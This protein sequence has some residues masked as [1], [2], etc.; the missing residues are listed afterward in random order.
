MALTWLHL[1]DL[2]VGRKD[3]GQRLALQSLIKAVEA[4]TLGRKCDLVIF[5]G[6]VANSGS[7]VEYDEFV[8]SILQP[9]RKMPATADAKY[10]ATP[11]NHDLDC[12]LTIPSPWSNLGKVR[13]SLFF[14]NSDKGRQVREPRARGFNEYA[15][16]CERNGIV[17]FDPIRGCAQLI[18][19]DNGIEALK[20]IAINTALFSDM[21]ESDKGL[22][23]APTLALRN[24]LEGLGVD[25][26][27]LIIGHHP[28]D[29]F[30]HTTQEQFKAA[31][32]EQCAVYLHGHE[33]RVRVETNQ[34]G[35]LSLGF[36]AAYQAP[37]DETDIS[38]Y[39]NGFAVCLLEERLHI[40]IHSWDNQ[41]GVWRQQHKLPHEFDCPSEM[42][43][44]G[45]SFEFPHRRKRTA[46]RLV[47][48]PDRQRR[49]PTC[50]RVVGVDPKPDRHAWV[51]LLKQIGV[52]PTAVATD[53]VTLAGAT[54]GVLDF[55][56]SDN[57]ATIFIR[58][59][60]GP[61]HVLSAREV[62]AANT[63]MDTEAH[64][65]LIIVSF[66]ELADDARK[67][68][69]QLERR[70]S[71]RILTNG[72][73]ARILNESTPQPVQ[74][75]LDELDAADVV[76][77]HVLVAPKRFYAV[78]DRL[79][80]D[81][82]YLLDAQ[83]NRLAESDEVVVRLRDVYAELR[84][85]VY[86]QKGD[87]LP[88]S[89][90]SPFDGQK[91]REQCKKEFETLKYAG[92]ATFGFRFPN[93]SIR[94]LYVPANADVSDSSASATAYRQ[95]VNDVLES[96]QLDDV[97]RAQFEAQLKEGLPNLA[98]RETGAARDLYQQHGSILVLGDPG[99]GK[100]CFLK[101]ELL[102]YC[103]GS[104]EENSWYKHHIPVFVSLAEAATLMGETI[105][106]V[107]I[108]SRLHLRRGLALGVSDLERHLLE[109]RVALFLDGLDEIPSVEQRARL[110]E[111]IKRHL[112]EFA[113][114]GNRLALTSRP[115]AIHALDVPKYLTTL[116]LRGLTDADMRV[117]A[118]NVLAAEVA[119]AGE[120]LRL[121][122]ELTVKEK[123]LVERL[124]ED[125]RNNQSIRRIAR[126]PLLLTLLVTIYA[127][128][129][130]L[131]AKKHRVYS[132]A[133]QTLVSVRN[134]DTKQHVLSESDLRIRLG[135][136]AL[137]YMF[138][139]GLQIPTLRSVGE[140][141]ARTLSKDPQDPTTAGEMERY[142]RLVAET[143]GLLVI[144]E[145]TGANN[146]PT[147]TF[148]HHSFL[149]YYAAIGF[150]AQRELAELGA[151][152]SYPRWREVISVIAGILADQRDSTDLIRLL[153]KPTSK[154]DEITLDRVLFALD[155]ALEADVPSE[156][157]QNAICESLAHAVDSGPLVVDGQLRIE[158]SERLVRL[159][160]ASGSLSL[161]NHL[162][163][164][165]RTVSSPELLAAY[166]DVVGRV[167][168]KYEMPPELSSI[169]EKLSARDE[170]SVRIAMCG[171]VERAPTLR[172][173]ATTHALQEALRGSAP[174]RFA[175]V[176]ALDA[177]PALTKQCWAQ[178]K[179]CLED[180]HTSIAGLA[181]RAVMAAGLYV[182]PDERAGRSLLEQCLRKWAEIADPGEMPSG[183]LVTPRED[184]DRLLSSPLLEDRLLGLRLLPVL[185]REERYVYERIFAIL[186]TDS[187]K[188][189]TEFVA[190]LE[191]LRLSRGA[192][193]L[194]THGDV[195]LLGE[196]LSDKHRDVRIGAAKA[197]AAV[198]GVNYR[199]I[200]LLRSYAERS[201]LGEF[202]VA[203]RA[204]ARVAEEDSDTEW[205]IYQQCGEKVEYARKISFGDDV[206]QR[207]LGALL[208]AC[209]ELGSIAGERLE[210][211]LFE[212]AD[213][214]RTP[215]L[216]RQRALRTLARVGRP[217]ADRARFFTKLL[218][219]SDAVFSPVIGDS[220]VDF[221][222]TARQRVEFVRAIF[223]ELPALEAALVRRWERMVGVAWPRS[224]RFNDNNVQALR[225]ALSDTRDLIISYG[226]FSVPA[227]IAAS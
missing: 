164:S 139:N 94:Q 203:I 199:V 116:H 50:Q 105:D 30:L 149:E 79:R 148:L 218:N 59:I 80:S 150:L 138:G 87:G 215:K 6:D 126:N 93:A 128:S 17:T 210:K 20:L 140:I 77:S 44:G 76:V 9:L 175:A 109:G 195:D 65:A 188:D 214:F 207:Q 125:C 91:Y 224:V 107:D 134:R 171:L 131:A 11:G 189:R 96:L 48:L 170:P 223:P 120:K 190:A 3:E 227:P 130:P 197:L 26:R 66:G 180:R 144:H 181:A 49:A 41:N 193:M 129:G 136:V 202:K 16:F 219:G 88:R 212:L 101:N 64:E 54:L 85:A 182:N 173:E 162:M 4:A 32:Y 60:S 78:F 39:D 62:E 68:A 67:L 121:G 152:A 159:L 8:T 113:P 196:M 99:S 179:L 115:A 25:D 89:E 183:H 84:S 37:L 160:S 114:L 31:I 55:V 46:T 123:E 213:S 141:I 14:Q 103:E 40:D 83:G 70:K 178:V 73:L 42:L 28:I 95:A 158:F 133:V 176:H 104:P 198:N 69:Q 200:E 137:D 118:S 98:Q 177:A 209:E 156:A 201:T 33:H 22:S 225:A 192:L 56:V 24:S 100:T 72:D 90:A 204:L 226:E 127:N 18:D 216:L 52:L 10:V 166:A 208:Q 142:V 81:W 57:D 169:I 184:V 19:F 191:A 71:F 167:E 111:A 205:F 119:Q 135:A 143:T 12:A 15:R 124:L 155:C 35:L 168:A 53:S 220:V 2:H 106:L 86:D 27:V 1:T 36:G 112:T 153:L 165:L 13:Q 161:T 194:M 47:T 45:Y 74:D 51:W 187:E 108:I 211:G 23:P 186:N 122:S 34:R 75:A 61:G 38:I 110:M 92:L 163:K 63:R 185:E 221:I 102:T 21:Y 29:W 5:T 172:T 174:V 58:G 154:A 97:Q 146:E 151:L 117:L 43:P 157:T 147:V 145:R 82:F 206:E 132:Q 217:D 222:K 7:A